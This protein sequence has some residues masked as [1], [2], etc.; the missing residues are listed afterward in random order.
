L[1]TTLKIV[2]NFEA[3]KRAVHIG[4]E[5]GI[6]PTTLRAIVDDKQKY[7]DVQN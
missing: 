1:E 2:A 6:P 7:R 4:R 3:E 5:V